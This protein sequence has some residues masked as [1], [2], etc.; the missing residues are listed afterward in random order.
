MTVAQRKHVNNY[1][2]KN[3]SSSKL[4]KCTVELVCTEHFNRR[5]PRRIYSILFEQSPLNSFKLTSRELE[6]IDCASEISIKR[7]S[8]KTI[9]MLPNERQH[10]GRTGSNYSHHDGFVIGRVSD[11]HRKILYT[12]YSEMFASKSLS[13]VWKK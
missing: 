11:R 3:K 8:H 7:I 1:L 5:N 10:V 6:I 9:S 12:F 13:S 2:K 4:K